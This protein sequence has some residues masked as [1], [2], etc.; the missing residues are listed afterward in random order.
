M[1]GSDELHGIQ[2]FDAS[3]KRLSFR[4]SELEEG[5]PAGR[6]GQ[7]QQNSPQQ[8]NSGRGLSNNS[9]RGSG[10]GFGCGNYFNSYRGGYNNSG[11]RTNWNNGWNGNANTNGWN[12]GGRASKNG[13]FQS[14]SYGRGRNNNMGSVLGPPP[15]N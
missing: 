3:G 4:P 12:N 13:G 1:A 2:F 7:Q 5:A 15:Q 14:T 9:G 10:G 8:H 11:S 6:V